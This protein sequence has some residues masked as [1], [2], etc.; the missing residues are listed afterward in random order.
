MHFSSSEPIVILG[1]GP[2]LLT[3]LAGDLLIVVSDTV[4]LAAGLETC[5]CRK[6][7]GDKVWK[8]VGGDGRQ[9]KFYVNG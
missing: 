4:L 3:A 5:A 8:P 2:S 7:G 9:D 6:V 1:A